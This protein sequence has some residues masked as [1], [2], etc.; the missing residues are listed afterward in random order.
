MDDK[1]ANTDFRPRVLLVYADSEL[2]AKCSR[3]FRRRGWEVRLANSADE[4]VR[5]VTDLAPTVVVVDGN[6]PGQ[7]GWQTCARFQAVRPGQP[8]VLLTDDSMPADSIAAARDT[9]HLAQRDSVDDLP[10]R[11]LEHTFV[12]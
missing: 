5:L 3:S 7:P 4:G 10:R 6:L 1:L 12:L 8:V 11:L 2:A 9:A